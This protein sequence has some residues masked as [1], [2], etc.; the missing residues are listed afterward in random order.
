MAF[1][2]LSTNTIRFGVSDAG[3]ISVTWGLTRDQGGDIFELV[4]SEPVV[5]Y[6]ELLAQE[7]G[8]GAL[9]L[10]KIVPSALSGKAEWSFTDERIVWKLTAPLTR[11]QIG[12][13]SSAL[14]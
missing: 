4:W 2:E 9:V 11:I 12:L 1:H 14:P 6:A 13:G 8:F 3:G 10:S 5:A 7:E